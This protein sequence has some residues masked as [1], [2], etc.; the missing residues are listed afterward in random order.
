[1]SKQFNI[2]Y[3]IYKNNNV[4]EYLL[5]KQGIDSCR[6]NLAIYKCGYNRTLDSI[7]YFL[8]N[9]KINSYSDDRYRIN[10]W[11]MAQSLKSWSDSISNDAGRIIELEYQI[12]EYANRID[13]LGK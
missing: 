10:A 3:E 11:T 5:L 9:N 2:P 6:N 7:K 8:E 1:M 13:E 4:E 12:K